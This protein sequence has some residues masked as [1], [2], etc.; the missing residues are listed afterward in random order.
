[1]HRGVALSLRAFVAPLCALIV[2]LSL[3][4]PVAADPPGTFRYTV[5]KGDNCGA[6]AVGFYGEKRYDLIHRH[7]DLGPTPHNLRPGQVLIL[8]RAE[9]QALVGHK[10]GPVRAAGPGKGWNDAYAGLGLYRRWRVNSLEHGF[11]E[12]VFKDDSSLSLRENTLLVIYGG[13]RSKTKRER[14]RA[15]LERGALRTRLGELAGEEVPE[16]GI[17]VSTAGSSAL[18]GAGSALVSVDEAGA[19]RIANHAGK[20]ARVRSKKAGGSEVKVSAG[21][22]SKVVRG[23]APTSPRKLPPSPSWTTD[24]A[25]HFAAIQSYGSVYARWNGVAKA[26]TYRVEL[27]RDAEGQN[28]VMAALVAADKQGIALRRV[29]VGVWYLSVIAIDSDRFES[30]P[31][32]PITAQVLAV[33]IED[34]V[35]GAALTMPSVVWPG[36]RVRVPAGGT[37]KT[38]ATESVQHL[39]LVREG[40]HRVQCTAGGGEALEPFELTVRTAGLKVDP[41]A[42]D[43]A[44]WHNTRNRVRLRGAAELLPHIT[45]ESEHAATWPP[46]VDGDDLIVEVL[47]HQNAPAQIELHARVAGAAEPVSAWTMDVREDEAK[48]RPENRFPDVWAGIRAGRFV[49]SPRI[50]VKD[51][52]LDKFAAPALGFRWNAT[53]RFLLQG[54]LQGGL[55][56]LG[57]ADQGPV[58]T[59]LAWSVGFGWLGTERPIRPLFELGAGQYVLVGHE[60]ASLNAFYGTARLGLLAGPGPALRL[61]IN[62]DLIASKTSGFATATG[63]TAGVSFEY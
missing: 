30:A 25:T 39:I 63:V 55:V 20:P 62:Q 3:A 18:L 46:Q 14:M 57:P 7:N 38:E 13:T 51:G 8:P 10:V 12:V 29:P 53:E 21:F 6:I 17:E 15:E 41:M 26:A 42:V 22:G 50:G 33:V 43:G 49:V 40:T 58:A 16:S 60:S 44:L 52:S 19:T 59:N 2:L 54:E 11:A 37:C 34:P 61:T 9:R 45:L 1:M 28:L 23:G 24:N 5:K 4:G 35:D 48:P 47:V 31:S 32:K 56:G 36:T 27:S